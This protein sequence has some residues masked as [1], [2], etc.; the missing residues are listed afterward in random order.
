MSDLDFKSFSKIPRLSKEVMTITEKVD[1]SN[2]L[3][4]ITEDGQFLTGSRNRWITPEDDNFG[5]SKWANEHKDE[6]M[7]L[8]PGY[9]YGEWFG[10]GIQRKY[11]LKDKRFALFANLEHMPTCCERIPVLYYGKFDMDEVTKTL[12]SLVATGSHIV[13]GFM[14]PEGIVIQLKEAGKRYKKLVVNDLL[15]KGEV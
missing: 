12:M 4:H 13:P 9:W 6:L 3:I 1:G 15:H 11:D 7:T 8:G 2:A 5:F 10:A 14:D